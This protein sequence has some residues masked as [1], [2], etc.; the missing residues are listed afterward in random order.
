MKESAKGRFFENPAYGK[1]RIKLYRQG[2]GGP[3][4]LQLTSTAASGVLRMFDRE[5][6]SKLEELKLKLLLDKR[7][8]DDKN[9]VAR[10]VP[11]D[12][13]VKVGEDGELELVKLEVATKEK[14]DEHTAK[15]YRKVADTIRPSR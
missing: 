11:A 13:D 10:E 15:V 4:G 3:I 12:V 8:V 6:K 14:A 1:H 7:Y 2:T 5:Y 9:K